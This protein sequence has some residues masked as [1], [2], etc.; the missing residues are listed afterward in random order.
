MLSATPSSLSSRSTRM[1]A[2]A[3]LTMAP[4]VTSSLSNSGSRPEPSSVARTRPG[5]S[6]AASFRLP[7]VALELQALGRE[8]AQRL[9]EDDEPCPAGLLCPVHRRIGVPEEPDRVA[10][11]V[12]ADRDADRSAEHDRPRLCSERQFQR[13]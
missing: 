2:P 4:S 3:L 12:R 11:D 1:T 9:G 7:Q 8:I 13:L 10:L 6:R 5:R